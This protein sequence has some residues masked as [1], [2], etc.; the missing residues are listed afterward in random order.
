MNMNTFTLMMNMIFQMSFENHEE[1]GYDPNL[2]LLTILYV[3]I[4]CFM[5]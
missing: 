2:E 4:V 5:S 1:N 3:L